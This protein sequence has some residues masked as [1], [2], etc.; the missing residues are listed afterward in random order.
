MLHI[1]LRS[2]RPRRAS[3]EH[4]QEPSHI[5]IPRAADS[6]L[7]SGASGGGRQILSHFE[8]QR[9]PLRLVV[10]SPLG[11]TH[12]VHE[13]DIPPTRCVERHLCHAVWARAGAALR[14]RLT[15]LLPTPQHRLVRHRA[16]IHETADAERRTTVHPVWVVE[17]HDLRRIPEGHVEAIAPIPPDLEDRLD[18]LG[19][20]LPRVLVET[21]TTYVPGAPSGRLS[22]L[23]LSG[24][25][26]Q[27][28]AGRSRVRPPGAT[29][30]MS[31]TRSGATN[32]SLLANVPFRTVTRTRVRGSRK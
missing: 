2:E 5:G 6:G 9:G 31:A 11:G 12:H 32:P 3:D 27:A 17:R 7:R 30:L 28:V 29:T 19:I 18:V 24:P 10:Q 23:V 21:P 26:L 1:H 15:A 4:Q 13:F 25:R 22:R 20:P 8:R 14:R 16:P